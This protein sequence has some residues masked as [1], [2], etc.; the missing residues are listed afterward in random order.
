VWRG[1]D[2]VLFD[3][4][5]HQLRVQAI[6]IKKGTLVD[7]TVI[8]SATHRDEEAAWARHK[9]RKAI[10]GFKAYMA[11]DA[12][13]TRQ[14]WNSRTVLSTASWMPWNTALWSG[15]HRNAVP[16]S[17]N[18]LLLRRKLWSVPAEPVLLRPY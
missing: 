9:R 18:A 16:G 15:S 5:T 2:R 3:D 11:A 14:T 10:H 17:N 4:V 7:A 6:T 12:C 1:L 8:A 13:L